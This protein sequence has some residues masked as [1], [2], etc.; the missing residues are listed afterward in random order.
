MSMLT[1][2]QAMKTIRENTAKKL[3]TRKANQEKDAQRAS[4]ASKARGASA[5]VVNRAITNFQK[6]ITATETALNNRMESIEAAEREQETV[7]AG[8]FRALPGL[9][10]S[11][12]DHSGVGGMIQRFISDG[13]I[14]GQEMARIIHGLAFNLDKVGDVMTAGLAAAAKEMRLQAGQIAA[15]EDELPGIAENA[16]RISD[17]TAT[18]VTQGDLSTGE[19][20]KDVA[21]GS[22]FFRGMKIDLVSVLLSLVSLKAARLYPVS[23][24]DGLISGL[25]PKSDPV[26]PM[27][28]IVLADAGSEVTPDQV[29][30][31]PVEGGAPLR[32]SDHKTWPVDCFVFQKQHVAL[33]LNLSAFVKQIGAAYAMSFDKWWTKL[34]PLFSEHIG[35]LAGM[36]EGLDYSLDSGFGFGG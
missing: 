32:A 15:I 16:S 35:G 26:Q 2:V 21:H 13:R 6:R 28:E 23:K 19:L 27:T 11:G 29:I 30:G 33:G 18:L 14:T 34:I 12:G 17:L 8:I 36:A 31:I 20:R 22:V 24:D 9:L 5:K 3:A 1:Q 10:K 25:I 7:T 4:G